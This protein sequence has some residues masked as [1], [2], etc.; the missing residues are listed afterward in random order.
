V[1]YV[2]AEFTVLVEIN[3]CV[4][5]TLK[6]MSSK[7]ECIRIMNACGFRYTIELDVNLFEIYS[8]FPEQITLV[9]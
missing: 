9:R 6:I 2:S 1:K 4:E 3:T 7:L 8:V 5:T